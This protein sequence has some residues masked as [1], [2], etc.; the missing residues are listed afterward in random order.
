MHHLLQDPWV[1]ARIE[2][3]VAPYRHLV[4]ADDLAFMQDEL[5]ELLIQDERA[6]RTLRRA[7][8]RE[9]VDASGEAF[10]GRFVE[11]SGNKPKRAVGR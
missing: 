1:K 9:N 4:S 6:A 5:A 2:A 10:V 8:P 11:A 3:A 7:R